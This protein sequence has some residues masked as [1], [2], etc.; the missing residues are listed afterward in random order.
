M[1][2]NCSACCCRHCESRAAGS[3]TVPESLEQKWSC[4]AVRTST[5]STV[6]LSPTRSIWGGLG[7]RGV[8]WRRMRKSRRELPEATACV[9]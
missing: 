2:W 5:G 7:R 3:R 1:A 9:A 8:S 6:S 4:Q